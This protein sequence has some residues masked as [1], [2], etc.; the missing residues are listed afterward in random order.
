MK[1]S[2]NLMLSMTIV[3]CASGR[4]LGSD[5]PALPE[6]DPDE[7][8]RKACA[9]VAALE[10]K[11]SILE[12]VSKVK[13]V[14]QRD[15][16]ERLTSADLVF[17]R[18]AAPPGKNNAKAID[19]T[20]PFFYVSVSLWAGRTQTP[21]ANLHVFEWKGQVYQMWIRVYGSDPELV[22]TVRKAVD[23]PLRGPF[24]AKPGQ[25]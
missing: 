23:E 19:D 5:L 16:N 1:R 3:V 15:A 8:F 12:G 6:R 2:L 25:K 4:I 7:T 17:A 22:K 9:L 10:G 11:H 21:P 20:K 14:V 24:A 18:N 13:P